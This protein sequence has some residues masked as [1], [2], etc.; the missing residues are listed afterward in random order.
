[1][2]E[3]IKPASKI[4]FK[5]I[6]NGGNLFLEISNAIDVDAI[7]ATKVEGFSPFI[8]R[9]FTHLQQDHLRLRIYNKIT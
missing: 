9:S 2:L 1:M 3:L 4:A 5:G 8:T 7:E 6:E